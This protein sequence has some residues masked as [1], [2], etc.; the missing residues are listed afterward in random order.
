M[1]GYIEVRDRNAVV[2][3]NLIPN[4]VILLKKKRQAPNGVIYPDDSKQR[5]NC[6]FSLSQECDL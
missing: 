2:L 5:F 1:L 4:M 6:N 3:Y